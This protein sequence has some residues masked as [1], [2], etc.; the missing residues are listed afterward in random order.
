MLNE[1]EKRQDLVGQVPL[2]NALEEL[3]LEEFSVM[4]L[5]DRLE[6]GICNDNCDCTNTNCPCTPNT[7][8]TNDQCGGGG[9][10]NDTCE[11]N[12]LCV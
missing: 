12:A 2:E 10:G 1:R 3:S 8:C 11:G 6:F 7:T 9:G 4:E 5:E